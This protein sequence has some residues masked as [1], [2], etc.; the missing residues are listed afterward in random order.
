MTER[1]K[2]IK[3]DAFAKRRAELSATQAATVDAKEIIAAAHNEAARIKSDLLSTAEAEATQKAQEL[4]AKAEASAQK[5]LASLEQD[6]SQLVAETVAKVVGD[7]DARQAVEAATK[8]GLSTLSDQKSAKIRASADVYRT[9]FDTVAAHSDAKIPV[10]QDETLQ[11]DR[12]ILSTERGH[13]EIG[14]SAQLSAA[15]DP[16]RAGA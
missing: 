10:T 2:I 5:E 9:V 13:S 7:L 1:A 6:V 4:L 3:R 12:V 14:L 11:G 15:T 8:I 16:W